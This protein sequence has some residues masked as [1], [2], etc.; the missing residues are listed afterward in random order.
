MI[1]KSDFDGYENIYHFTDNQLEFWATNDCPQCYGSGLIWEEGDWQPYGDTM[2]KEPD[3]FYVCE[4]VEGNFIE[5]SFAVRGE[6]RYYKQKPR[7]R[8]S[9]DNSE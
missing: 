1:K 6:Y 4:C 7:R 8:F 5:Y 2:A 3:R 9:T